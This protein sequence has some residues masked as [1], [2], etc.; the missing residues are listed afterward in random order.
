LE[1]TMVLMERL[2]HHKIPRHTEP[3]WVLKEWDDI[4]SFMLCSQHLLLPVVPGQFED[5]PIAK[6][7]K[8]QD[9]RDPPEM[10]TKQRSAPEGS[11][12]SKTGI[13]PEDD[14]VEHTS[15]A[16][17]TNNGEGDNNQTLPLG[18]GTTAGGGD[19]DGYDSSSSSGSPPSASSVY[20]H[21]SIR[22]TKKVKKI[23]K[24]A[25]RGTT[26][27]QQQ[28]ETTTGIVTP[29][30]SSN[31]SKRMKGIKITVR[32]EPNR[33]EFTPPIPPSPRHSTG[34]PVAATH[35]GT[36][37]PFLRDLPSPRQ[38]SPLTSLA[39]LAPYPN[40]IWPPPVISLPQPIYTCSYHH[41]L[42]WM[43][44]RDLLYSL[45]YPEL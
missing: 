33:F 26:P 6:R 20:R 25:D 1:P 28:W 30:R 34:H 19:D 39:C 32:H 31:M 8:G 35:P 17:N 38:V 9:R 37:S 42:S 41:L 14:I 4:M 13:V 7:P 10:L 29:Q 40:Q 18:S 3:H 45:W 16:G 21:R 22:K 43:L 15:E 44:S 11:T 5:P 12:G 36:R 27:E 23:K 24:Q 2:K